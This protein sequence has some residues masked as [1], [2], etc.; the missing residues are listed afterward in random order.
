VLDGTLI[1]E[2]NLFILLRAAPHLKVLSFLS[3]I[4]NNAGNSAPQLQL[5]ENTLSQLTAVHLSN[6]EMDI[7]TLDSL[8]RAAPRIS[9]VNLIHQIRE[10][11]LE[12]NI[13]DSMYA[14]EVY[15]DAETYDSS[16]EPI[17][18]KKIF[19][20]I[21]HDVILPVE[22]YRLAVFNQITL[23]PEPCSIAEAF[24]LGHGGDL[25]LK[26]RT[27]P[28]STDEI[29]AL[30][31]QDRG[32]LFYGSQRLYVS[33]DWQALASLSAEEELLRYQ[34]MPSHHP[35][36]IQYSDRD[37]LYYLKSPQKGWI[38][39]EYTLL[40]NRSS[41]RLIIE[42]QQENSVFAAFTNTPL[43]LEKEMNR[44]QDYL[45]AINKQ[46]KGSCR[47]RTLLCKY[48]ADRKGKSMRIINNDCHSFVELY[49]NNQWKKIDL[50]G[51]P[52]TVIMDESN[53]FNELVPEKDIIAS[54]TSLEQS[55]LAEAELQMTNNLFDSALH[56]SSRPQAQYANP[57]EYYAH[58]L[59][60]VKKRL[61][62]CTS[63]TL[64]TGLRFA[65]DKYAREQNIPCFYAHTPSDLTLLQLTLK[66]ATRGQA[67]FESSFYPSALGEFITQNKRGVLLINYATFKA[68]EWV[69]YNTLL[70][71]LRELDK[72]RIPDDLIVLG[73]L[74]HQ[75][76]ASLPGN[77]FYSRFDVVE[78]SP[79]MVDEVKEA[80][81]ALPASSFPPGQEKEARVINL[82]NASDWE[83]RLLG[84]WVLNKSG[85]K[86]QS[87]LLATWR[88]E[89]VV[90]VEIQNGLWESEDFCRFWQ[91][92]QFRKQL[93]NEC[94]LTRRDGY[95]WEALK[96]YFCQQAG[97]PIS[98][99]KF[100]ILNPSTL[101]Y[102]FKQ[103]Q[104]VGL[105]L[106][107]KPGLI[108]KAARA[109]TLSV[110][111]T[112]ALSEHDWARLL[113]QC[114]AFKVIL[115]VY[116]GVSVRLPESLQDPSK[117]N[118]EREVL[119]FKQLT[120]VESTD[121]DTTIYALVHQKPNSVVLDVT[122]VDSGA[123]FERIQGEVI[124]EGSTK[125][126]SFKQHQG[127]FHQAFQTGK[128]L[129]LRGVCSESVVDSMP[130]HLRAL[131]SEYPN[132]TCV[133]V[134][135]NAAAFT[136]VT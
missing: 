36:E 63:S 7:T 78:A 98:K 15:L 116:L 47:H 29:D 87:G 13:P 106:Q 48:L 28:Y 99:Q 89:G 104:V 103:H 86:Y 1:S 50:G 2:S 11:S 88:K 25:N 101:D 53:A 76:A 6:T 102:F 108:Q 20:P 19:Q 59:N 136:F 97:K 21:G 132:A 128:T 82:F 56:V 44:G 107:F 77:D 85:W 66:N 37:N 131:E 68:S 17:H 119:N 123:L 38:N 55:S 126:L 62:E 124:T 75:G 52:V 110:Y 114:Q 26:P 133:I 90:A 12:E 80:I 81:P 24:I 23:N 3:G 74:S 93:P 31:F 71:D 130:L 27:I 100:H 129:I 109:K 117:S 67:Q 10:P 92:V 122:G 32:L 33:D 69:R 43:V 39:I 61:I 35:I 16:D 64:L 111:V 42:N 5:Q 70:D 60:G 121:V 40:V 95:T 57:S 54:S 46:R 49:D 135:D 65:L 115:Q 79:V 45:I 112:R 84:A 83:N 34:T 51:T 134:C 118:L 18:V 4:C 105:D 94:V 72:Q 73:L 8:C 127:A 14:S 22:Q 120:V 96:A 113:T 91:E 9:R 30:D 58:C 125:K 41:L